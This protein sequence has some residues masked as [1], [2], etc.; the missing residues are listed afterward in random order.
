[1]FLVIMALALM[2]YGLALWAWRSPAELVAY[3]MLMRMRLD[4][5]PRPDLAIVALDRKTI[6]ELGGL[7]W[8]RAT[9]AR[10]LRAL[11]NGGAKYVVYDIL[12]DAPDTEHPGAD[13]AF[14]SVLT[15]KKNAYLPIVYDPLKTPEWDPS[16]IRALIYM[17]RYAISERISY[18]DG[19]PFYRYYYFTPPW[20]DFVSAANGVGVD[21]GEGMG[22]GVARSVRLA[23][24]TRIRYPVPSKLLPIDITLPQ[25]TDRLVV[26]PGLPLISACGIFDVEKVRVQVQF[27]RSIDLLAELYPSVDIPID[28][29]GDMLVNY[30][31]PVGSFPTYS[32]I[33]LLQGKIDDTA[34]DGKTV[35][36]GVTD[37]TIPPA[38]LTTPYG[39][40]PKVEVTANAVSTILSRSYI[41]RTQREAL[42]VL[43]ILGVLLGLMLPLINRWDL[44]PTAIAI[45][46]VYIVLAVVVL[47][48]FGHALP[49]I[50]AVL[51]ILLGSAAAALL[52]PLMFNM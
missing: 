13:R 41:T 40:M 21:V 4:S 42:A 38:M 19:T 33:D 23:Y 52:K 32:A 44:G 28:D 22:D 17:E 29:N 20:A 3:D 10:I 51:L 49:L 25:L 48:V 15:E 24:L 2:M 36:V 5:H 14:W 43:L 37:N 47:S 30:I 31:G 45:S 35:F 6:D 1:M 26:L 50:P 9:H 39:K 34:L 12:L 11:R 7:P 27:G 46:L 16:D 8:S 18:P